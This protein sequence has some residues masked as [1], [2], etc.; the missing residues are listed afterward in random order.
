[1]SHTNYIEAM[2]TKELLIDKN[3]DFQD[4]RN[5]LHYELMKLELENPNF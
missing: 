3:M 5:I 4:A 1:M 2:N